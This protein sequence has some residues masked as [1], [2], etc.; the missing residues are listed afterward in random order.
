MIFF[1]GFYIIV[2][3]DSFEHFELGLAEVGFA[4]WILNLSRQI[5]DILLDASLIKI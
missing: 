4:Q 3:N 1:H 2:F 5:A